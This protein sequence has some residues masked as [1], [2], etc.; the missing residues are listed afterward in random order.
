MPSAGR[1]TSGVSATLVKIV[2]LYE[3]ER[4]VGQG[5]QREINTENFRAAELFDG[6]N[7]FNIGY[8]D[9]ISNLLLRLEHLTKE[10]TPPGRI[11]QELFRRLA[12]E[13]DTSLRR[14]RE[15]HMMDETRW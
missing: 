4:L 12:Y 1:Q 5:Y 11:L 8:G 15:M 2:K 10:Q 9:V 3:T 14:F 6:M 13:H 7:T